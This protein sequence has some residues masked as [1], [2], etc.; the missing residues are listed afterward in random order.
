VKDQ[1]LAPGVE[2]RE[3]AKD[4]AEPAGSDIRECLASGA[5][6]D[7]VND[8]GRVEGQSVEGVGDGEDDVEV[9]NVEHF[10]APLLE[11][12]RACLGAAPGTVPVAARVPEDM[13]IVAAVTVI[14]VAAQSLGAAVR[15]GTQ[16]LALG[17]RD[18]ATGEKLPALRASDR[19]E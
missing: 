5:E 8:L 4:R 14:A 15:D 16:H 10:I 1:R 18:R 2:H 9:R 19:A 3:H 6:Q 11:P 17:G 13:L 7:C 12:A